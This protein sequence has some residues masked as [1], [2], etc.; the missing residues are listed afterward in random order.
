M[1]LG[2]DNLELV[3]RIDSAVGCSDEEYSGYLEDLD[4]AKLKLKE[5]EEPTRFVMRKVLPYGVQKQVMNEQLKIG[6]RGE[7]EFQMG[8]ILEEVRCSLI[9]IKNPASLPEEE[10]VKFIKD[11]DGYA[12][13][14]LIAN[15]SSVGVLMDLYSARRT[16]IDKTKKGDLV[17][18][19]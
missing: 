17:K 10:K 4:E 12:S 3:L 14:Q 9:D 6:Q 16:Y 8:H 5:G 7:T 15:L 13:K 2:K 1:D 11:S 18:K 19:S